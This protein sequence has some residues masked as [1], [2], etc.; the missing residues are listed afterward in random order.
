MD[1]TELKALQAER[2]E[3][4]QQADEAWVSFCRSLL[5]AGVEGDNYTALISKALKYGASIRKAEWANEKITR[6]LYR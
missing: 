2:R 1:N 4:E 5:D 3:L 6:L